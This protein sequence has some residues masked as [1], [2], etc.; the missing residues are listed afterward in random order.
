MAMRWLL[1]AI[2]A[3]GCT[4]VVPLALGQNPVSADPSAKGQVELRGAGAT[5]PAPLYQKWIDVYT[6]ANPNISIKYQ[7][8]GSGEGSQLFLEQKV[9]FGASDA[10]LS[11]AQIAQA[12]AGVTLVPTT[13]GIIVLA[14]NLPDVKGTLKLSRDVYADIFAGKIRQWDDPRIQALNP[15]LKLPKQT[16]TLVARKDSS[17]TTYALTNH[18]S[19]ISEAWRTQGP[20]VG[21]VIEWP[22][23]STVARGNEGVAGRIK[24]SWGS[25]GYVEYGFAKRL[26]LPMVYLQNKAGRY[27]EPGPQSG[28]AALAANVNQIPS[29]LRL[30]LPDPDGENSYPIITLTWLLL[31]NHYVEPQKGVALK[32]FVDWALTDGQRF[33]GD[34]GYIPLPADLAMRARA[35]VDAVQ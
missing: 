5:F 19:T 23:I 3:F 15:D 2:A 25:I 24:H 11:D 35:A 1:A 17:G 28:Q 26:G 18:L 30:F 20:G 13:A 9:D 7:G 33:S 12:K 10:A 4:A 22:G 29:N 8:V 34:M 27:V 32:G 31:H 6:Q 14:Y 21:K 16:I